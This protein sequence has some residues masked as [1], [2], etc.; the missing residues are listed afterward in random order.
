MTRVDCANKVNTKLCDRF[1]V[2][3]YQAPYWGPPS[4]F[5]CGGWDGKDEKSDIRPID[6]ERTA[7]RLL[8]WINKILGSSYNLEDKKFEDDHL[9]SNVSDPGQP[10][11]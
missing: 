4:K 8:K 5:V 11:L 1:S 3:F 9:H 10:R 2:S 6:D 7:E